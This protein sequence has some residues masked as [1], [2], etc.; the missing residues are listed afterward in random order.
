[1][2][3]DDDDAKIKGP[4]AALIKYL[5]RQIEET[6]RMQGRGSQKKK[7]KNKNPEEKF[8]KDE[9][10]PF[11]RGLGFSI[12]VMEAKATFNPKAGRYISQSLK[13]GTSDIVGMT[14]NAIAAFIE[15]KA[16]GKRSNIR[17]N[18]HA[19]LTEKIKLGAFAVC[20]DSVKHLQEIYETWDLIEDKR[21][22]INYLLKDLPELKNLDDYLDFGD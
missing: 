17:P 3:Q 8:I 12:Q 13:P 20:T 18:Q 15:A 16:P 14:P 19:F 7:K 10:L 4:K 6:K 2:S 9:L 21:G 11:L 22:K 1:M 5:D